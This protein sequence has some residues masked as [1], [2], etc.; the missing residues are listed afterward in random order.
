MDI[1]YAIKEPI[2]Q[3]AAKILGQGT[4]IIPSEHKGIFIT[5]FFIIFA[6]VTGVGIVV[7]LLPIYAHDLGAA[8]IYVAM[9]F[10]AFSISRTF[11]L[12]LFGRLSDRKGRKPFIMTGLLTYVLVSLAF[13]WSASVEGLI[14]IR[15]LQGAGSAMIMPVVQAYVG[16]ITPEGTEGYSMGL[17]N[18]SMFLSLSLGPF[19]GGTI[20]D[21][22]SMDGA[23]YCMAGLSLTGLLLCLIFLPPLSVEKIRLKNRVPVPFAMVVR[24]W[25]LVGLVV[26]RYAYTACIGIIWCFL[27]LYASTA[28]GLSGSRI[29]L[30]VMVGVFVSGLLQLPMGYAADRIDKKLMVIAGGLVSTVGIILPFWASSFNDLLVAVF[31]FGV[32]GGISMPAISALAVVKGEEKQAM[33]SVMS[34]MTVAHSMGMFTGSVLAGL[35]MDFFSLS[36]AFPCGFL[37]MLAGSFAFPLIYRRRNAYSRQ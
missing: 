10:G 23:F 32:G 37:I 28:F 29:G 2:S 20:L 35:S 30:L 26:F 12:P 6:T 31:V 33:A 9:I 18:L 21:L 16:E 7:P 27:P 22:W 17:F 5:L 25:E 14:F 11:L 15:F 34:V 8:G 3:A 24:D 1:F 19:M 4:R 13:V 36:Y